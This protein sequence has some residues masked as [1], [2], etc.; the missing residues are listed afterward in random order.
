MRLAPVPSR[1]L[2]LVNDWYWKDKS[3]PLAAIEALAQIKQ[4]SGV[5]IDSFTLDDGWDFDWDA[6]SGIWGRLHRTRFAGGWDALQAAGRP[7]EINISLWFGPIG[8]YGERPNRIAFGRTLGYEVQGDKFCLAAASLPP[9]CDREFFTLGVARDGL[10]Q[11]GRL[12]S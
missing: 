8:G 9:A 6:D 3:Q 2:F 11:G 4:D 7:A 5:P 1:M 10:H 12:F